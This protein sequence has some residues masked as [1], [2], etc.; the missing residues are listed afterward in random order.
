MITI[1]TKDS[2]GTL[3]RTLKDSSSIIRIGGLYKMIDWGY[4]SGTFEESQNR[5]IPRK[6]FYWAFTSSKLPPRCAI[7]S[8]R[9]DLAPRW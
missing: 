8:L 3:A 6:D 1:C 7:V 5:E 9:P 2:G 4:H